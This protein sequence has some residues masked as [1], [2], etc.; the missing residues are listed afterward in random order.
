MADGVVFTNSAAFFEDQEENDLYFYDG[1]KMRLSEEVLVGECSR[2]TAYAGSESLFDIQYSPGETVS[3]RNWWVQHRNGKFEFWHGLE[4]DFI[5]GVDYRHYQCFLGDYT[6]FLILKWRYQGMDTNP[7]FR[8]AV[9][10]LG[11][12]TRCTAMSKVSCCSNATA[13]ITGDFVV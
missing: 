8:V 7:W 11:Q 1:T 9:N 10:W 2:E 13:K 3:L 5:K 6:L 4:I 12:G